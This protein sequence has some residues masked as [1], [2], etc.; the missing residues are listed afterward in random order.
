L[1]QREAAVASHLE[2]MRRLDSVSTQGLFPVTQFYLHKAQLMADVP[3]LL[4]LSK[5]QARAELRSIR[6][7][8]EVWSRDCPANFS[9]GQWLLRAEEARLD[10]DLRQTMEAYDQAL[11]TSSKGKLRHLT[12]LIATRAS[13]FWQQ[14]GKPS[15]AA[16]YLRQAFTAYD[17]WQATTVLNGWMADD[18]KLALGVC[19]AWCRAEPPG[20]SITIQKFPPVN[21]QFFPVAGANQGFL[22]AFL[23]CLNR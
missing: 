5:A 3:E 13:A 8:F 14:T 21:I 12:A 20:L 1:G 16:T 7:R 15:F 9:P 2:A 6:Q 19:K 18:S 17:D 22:L 11:D 23:L 10:G 4:G